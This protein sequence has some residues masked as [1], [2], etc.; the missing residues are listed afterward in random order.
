MIE[1]QVDRGSDVEVAVYSKKGGMLLALAWFRLADLLDE[2]VLKSG[3]AGVNVSMNDVEE[4]W[5]DMEPSG[6]L[7]SKCYFGNNMPFLLIL[8]YSH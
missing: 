8:L 3:G 7:L 4:S 5:I 2:S 6:Q 1:V